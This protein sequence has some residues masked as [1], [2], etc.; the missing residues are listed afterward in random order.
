MP[1]RLD[2]RR[3]LAVAG[4]TA[5]L[6]WLGCGQSAPAAK[7]VPGT[8]TVGAT[9]AGPTLS[10][11]FA[12]LSYEKTRLTVPLFTPS[13]AALAAL[14]RLIGPGVLRIG[15]NGVDTSS[16]RGAVS[17]LTPITPSQVDDFCGL[18]TSVGW[19]VIWGI[20][21]AKNTPASAADEA[22]YVA[23][24]LGSSLLAFEIGNEV[25]LYGGNGDRPAT[26]SYADFLAEW[27]QYAASIRSAVP[28]APLSGPA[29]ASSINGYAV[30]FARDA[31]G[32]ISL[33]THHYYRANGR[34]STSTLELLLAPDP[35]LPGRLATLV[36]AAE[37]NGIAGGFRMAECNSFYNGGAPGISDAHGTALWVLDYLF[38]CALGGATGVNLHGG[39]N[40]TG[41]T[42]IGDSSGVVASVRPEF[43]GVLLF[44]LAASG[45]ALPVT[46][47]V[48]AGLDVTAYGV[49]R[50][51]GGRN[52]V[53]INK[54]GS[55]AVERSVQTGSAASDWKG[56]LLTGPALD[57]AT[58]TTLGGAPVLP[59]GS[60][61]PS[62]SSLS[63]RAGSLDVHV[64]A[65][66]AVL[67]RSL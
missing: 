66:S 38:T 26:W 19:Q 42:P 27:R 17:G 16:W 60:W 22:G 34:L 52:V 36:G 33:L 28:G 2:R 15:A 55:Q 10:T 20:N 65:A 21:L 6:P 5:V 67:L 29:T 40:G 4:A 62:W 24:R 63:A 64:P 39:G 18:L 54:D 57:S 43:H 31:G 13:N 1:L 46:V 45:R 14:L 41:Y 61:T 51:D 59:D 3:F 47:D 9:P 32:Q 30:P 53:V 12:G 11:R 48:P 50:T 58:G 44:A 35:A 7:G 23:Q 25:D 8:A 56:L 49:D 37:S